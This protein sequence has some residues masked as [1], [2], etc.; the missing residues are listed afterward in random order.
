MPPTP[1]LED[2]R[3]FGRPTRA[4]VAVAALAALLLNTTAARADDPSLALAQ[5]YAPVLRLVK[6]KE[7]CAYGEP[8]VPTNVNLVLGNPEVA[9]RGP[10]DKTNI[11]KV[12]PTADDLAKGLPD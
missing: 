8:Y 6:Q 3:S 10:W 9:F 1:A 4:V 5:R 12:G 7:P 2:T 11:V